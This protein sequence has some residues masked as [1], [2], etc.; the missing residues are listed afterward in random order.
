MD[1]YLSQKFLP[2][3]ATKVSKVTEEA[4]TSTIEQRNISLKGISYITSH[5]T[6]CLSSIALLAAG[7]TGPLPSSFLQYLHL[8][9][10]RSLRSDPSSRSENGGGKKEVLVLAEEHGLTIGRK[11]AVQ[12]KSF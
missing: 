7:S 5:C 8:R 3:T 11:G 12:R 6:A 2:H 10:F 1:Y 4:F 9:P